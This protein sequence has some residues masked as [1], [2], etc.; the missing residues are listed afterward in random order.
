MFGIF[1]RK[2]KKEKLQAEY[3]KLLRESYLLSSSNRK[4]SDKK[5]FE[6]DQIMN[7]IEK[8]D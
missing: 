2:S 6:A 5:I 8:M 4:M 7:I 3:E 1:K